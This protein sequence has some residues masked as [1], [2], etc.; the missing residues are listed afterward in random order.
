[1]KNGI[2]IHFKKTADFL[3]FILTTFFASMLTT[4]F[5]LTISLAVTLV[6]GI[7]EKTAEMTLSVL[8]Y[9]GHKNLLFILLITCTLLYSL[10]KSKLR[11]DKNGGSDLGPN[12][13]NHY[14]NLATDT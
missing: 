4:G 10:N 6:F 7:N 12:L 11:G 8:S 14:D 13:G 2:K 1:M 9:D 5:C 3:T